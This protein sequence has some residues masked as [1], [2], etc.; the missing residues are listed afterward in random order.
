MRECGECTVC[1]Y[2]ASIDGLTDSYTPCKY[3]AAG[4]TIFGL[5]E[6][7]AVCSSFQCSWLRGFGDDTDRP[8]LIDALFTI[9]ETVPGKFAAFVGELSRNAISTTARQTV[10]QFAR[11]HPLPL[12]VS[13][14][15]K[16]TPGDW[17]ILHAPLRDLA[18]AMIGNPVLNLA[19]DVT[20][21]ERVEPYG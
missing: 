4:C 11:Q 7:P 3:Q 17:V 18:S 20:M 6:R 16:D 21:Y 5:P 12:I 1:C 2:V 14:H 13:E 10:V 19:D 15:G 9:N 8:D